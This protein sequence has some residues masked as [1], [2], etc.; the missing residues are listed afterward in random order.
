MN[1]TTRREFL[2]DAALAGAA[3]S[4]STLA[5]GSL[6]AAEAPAH[7]SVA[8][9]L[10]APRSVSLSLLGNEPTL[11]TGISWGVPWAQ[12]A[13]RPNTPFALSGNGHLPLQSWPMAYWPDGSLKWSGFATVVPAG[14]TG[15]ITLSPSWTDAPG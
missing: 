15:P 7:A 6:F 8:P 4:T 14:L 1:Q 2:K 11:S 13:V 12:G 10:F 5:R 9:A 3:I